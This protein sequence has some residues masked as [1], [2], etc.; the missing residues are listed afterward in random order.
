[1]ASALYES[2]IKHA[3]IIYIVVIQKDQ[4]LRGTGR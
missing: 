1:M 4:A 2:L 3:K